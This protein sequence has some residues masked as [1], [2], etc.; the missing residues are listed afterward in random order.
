[1]RPRNPTHPRKED[2][3]PT[4]TTRQHGF[5]IV[6]LMIV[7]AII[8][9]LLAVLIPAIK[10]AV[11]RERKIDASELADPAARQEVIRVAERARFS[12]VEVVDGGLSARRTAWSQIC[13]ADGD[14]AYEVDATDRQERRVRL[15]VCCRQ[16]AHI[17]KCAIPMHSG[18]PS[19]E[20]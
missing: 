3:V 18:A 11:D 20:R 5:T 14:F 8:G 4:T 7:V 10:R 12:Q 9:I 1:M 16:V 13:R 19:E 6:E 17:T 2:L 15:T